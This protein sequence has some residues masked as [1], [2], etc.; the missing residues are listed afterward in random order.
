[1]YAV[2]FSYI[3]FVN[4]TNP[5]FKIRIKER[6]KVRLMVYI[7][8]LSFRIAD[9]ITEFKSVSNFFQYFMKGK[10]TLLKIR[11]YLS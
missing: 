7:L 1:M 6:K 3:K 9:K 5:D 11:F 4:F 10:Q 2:Y 8:R